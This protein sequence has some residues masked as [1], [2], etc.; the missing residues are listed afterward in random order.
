VLEAT[1]SLDLNNKFPNAKLVLSSTNHNKYPL[2]KDRVRGHLHRLEFHLKEVGPETTE[3]M[4]EIKVD[5][6]RKATTIFSRYYSKKMD[7]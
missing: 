7:L 6:Q 1:W 4:V 5:P 2:R 3:I